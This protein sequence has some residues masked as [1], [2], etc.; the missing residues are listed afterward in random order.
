MSSTS[1][2]TRS[3]AYFVSAHGF[4]HAARSAAV[5]AAI[6]HR[7]PEAH[8]HIFTR[9]PGWF[10]ADA[11]AGPHTCHPLET[12]VGLVQRSPLEEDM[13]E[14][15][16]RLD[17]FFPLRPAHLEACGRQLAACDCQLVI[18]DIA[19]LGI[20]AANALG[21]PSILVENFTWDW[22]YARYP[23]HTHS[24]AIRKRLRIHAGYQAELNHGAS[25]RIQAEPVCHALRADLTVP[26][27][28]RVS[29]MPAALTRER[30]GIGQERPLVL[31]TMGGTPATY[32]FLHHLRQHKGICFLLPGLGTTLEREGNLIKLPA[33]SSFRHPDL[34]A[35]ADA[36]V[37]KVGYS[38]LAEIYHAGTPFGFVQRPDFPE[39]PPLAEYIRAEM[40][41]LEIA[42]GDFE[43]GRWVKMLEPLLALP[44]HPS[45]TPNG[46][47]LIA[48][49][50]WDRITSP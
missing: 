21:L 41:A 15:L 3:I 25:Y 29:K 49:F 44:R 19:A 35:A 22:I 26:P 9:A 23:A 37:G 10:F 46:A 32:N 11:L 16:A 12:D 18:C 34:I 7:W 33:R 8:F 2:S 48:D 4:G 14:T 45:S 50:V 30:L 1:S 43:E 40:S 24:P 13:E 31:V 28:C 27:A 38:T 17:A 20:A 6:Q 42:P 47:D 39:S 36:V 5:M